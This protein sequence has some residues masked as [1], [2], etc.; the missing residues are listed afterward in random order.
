[1]TWGRVRRVPWPG[2]A[3]AVAGSGRPDEVLT[4]HEDPVFRHHEVVGD[5]GPGGDPGRPAD[6][7]PRAEHR[8]DTDD[9]TRADVADRAD[10][11]LL[12]HHG[13]PVDPGALTD[14]RAR[15]DDRARV[16]VGRG[17]D[18]GGRVHPG[19]R[20]HEASAVRV[21]LVAE[22]LARGLLDLHVVLRLAHD[23]AT[24]PARPGFLF[25]GTSQGV[26]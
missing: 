14:P 24:S 21:T 17:V 4:T 26:G 10:D 16:D 12:T 2:Q 22:G 13:A 3:R 7:D 18:V 5:P 1:M 6:L 8:A 25:S 9:R 11:G 23:R 19:G 20:L 15:T